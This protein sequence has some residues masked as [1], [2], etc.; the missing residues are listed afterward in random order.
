[1]QMATKDEVKQGL[2]EGATNSRIRITLTCQ[3]V[4]PLE[5]G[6]AR[7]WPPVSAAALPVPDAAS[8]YTLSLQHHGG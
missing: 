3:D 5:K 7:R 2:E 6:A 1:M 8:V 4:A